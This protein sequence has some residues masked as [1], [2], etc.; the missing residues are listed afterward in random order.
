MTAAIWGCSSQTLCGSRRTLTAISLI[1][2]HTGKDRS[3][4]ARGHSS[5]RAALDTEIELK[6]D[7]LVRVASVT[8]QRD[9][10]SGK[11]VAFTLEVVELGLDND[12]EAVTSCVVSPADVPD[13]TAKRHA[14]MATT[15]LH[16]KRCTTR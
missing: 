8:K 11:K 1:V 6:V 7:G 16:T 9:M 15:K 14:W 2:H 10:E 13:S 5:L 4:G 3:K 12:L